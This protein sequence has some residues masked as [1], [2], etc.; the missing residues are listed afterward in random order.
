MNWISG[1]KTYILGGAL[2]VWGVFLFATG[3][4]EEGT[5]KLIEGL[6]LIFLRQGVTK[7]GAQ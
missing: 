7:S 4:Q 2:V 5:N 3:S 6:A 1:K